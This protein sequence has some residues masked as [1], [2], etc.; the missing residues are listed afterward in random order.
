[1]SC[2]INLLQ[3]KVIAFA[4]SAAIGA[5]G[6]SFYARWMTV[7]TPDGFLFWESFFV[8]CM[9]VLGGLGNIWG[10]LLGAVVLVGLGELLRELLPFWGFRRMPAFYSTDLSWC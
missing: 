4:I 10:V 5:V 9:I 6:G 3:Y 8:L 7:I 1:V 2:G